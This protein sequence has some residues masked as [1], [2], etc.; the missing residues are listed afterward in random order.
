L[1]TFS[2]K[3]FLYINHFS[4]FKLFSVGW[5]AVAICLSSAAAVGYLLLLA[6]LLGLLN[7]LACLLA[8]NSGWW[9]AGIVKNTGIIQ[10]SQTNFTIRW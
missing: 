2:C 7:Y 6:S 10:A 3:S 9:L 1:L 4:A 8:S 5:L